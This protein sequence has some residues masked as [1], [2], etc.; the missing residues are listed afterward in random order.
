VFLGWRKDRMPVLFSRRSTH[1]R[2]SAG[3][4]HHPTNP[5]PYGV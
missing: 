5:G 4:R 1:C 2:I 3:M